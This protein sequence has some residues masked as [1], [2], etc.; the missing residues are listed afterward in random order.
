MKKIDKESFFKILGIEQQIIPKTLEDQIFQFKIRQRFVYAVKHDSKLRNYHESLNNKFLNHIP[1][2]NAAKAFRKGGSYFEFLEPHR[3]NYNFLRLDLKSFFHSINEETMKGVFSSYFEDQTIE[4]GTTKQKLLDSFLNLVCLQLSGTN[5]NKSFAGKSIVP[6]G[7]KTS[8]V[9]SNVIFRQLDI[10]IQRHCIESGIEYTRYAD[11]LLFSSES[12]DKYLSSQT[13]INT[14]AK[15]LA[16]KEL[17]LNNKK[18]TFKKHLLSINGHVIEG[19]RGD[20]N[21]GDVRLSNGKLKLLEK[22]L[23][24]LSKNTSYEYILKKVFSIDV[25]EI[26]FPAAN[27][28]QAFLDKYC[29]DQLINKIAGYRSYLISYL[30][31]LASS[32]I[33]NSVSKTRYVILI[34]KLE[35]AIN[36]IQ[37]S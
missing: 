9:I 31:F 5:R 27:T 18:T 2:N 23:H 33:N 24:E 6:M 14:I 34:G 12:N 37:S 36:K 32:G 7:F 25:Q 30:K 13:F 16:S 8:P 4:V 21:S 15:I 20:L 28:K 11:D 35:K 26:Q 17:K 22:L 1:L 3:F 29:R 10:I 19:A